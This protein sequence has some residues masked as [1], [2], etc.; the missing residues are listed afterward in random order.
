MPLKTLFFRPIKIPTTPLIVDNDTSTGCGFTKGHSFQVNWL[1]PEYCHGHL[2]FP[3]SGLLALPSNKRETFCVVA[4]GI[5]FA[6][7]SNHRV[8]AYAGALRMLFGR[9]LCYPLHFRYVENT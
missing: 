6:L 7:L 9:S 4:P 5:T 3:T 8:V 2:V 1:G